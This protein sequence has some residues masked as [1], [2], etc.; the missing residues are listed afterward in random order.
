VH[1]NSR[2]VTHAIMPEARS[3]RYGEIGTYALPTAPHRLDGGGEGVD[4]RSEFVEAEFIVRHHG[5]LDV[6][7]QAVVRGIRI[8]ECLTAC[9]SHAAIVAGSP[10]GKREVSALIR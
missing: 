4:G 7:T 10:V 6:D 9:I 1:A 2:S 8:T 5:L 3:G